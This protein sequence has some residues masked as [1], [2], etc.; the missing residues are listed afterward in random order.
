MIGK[1]AKVF[2]TSSHFPFLAPLPPVHL[3]TDH[4][5][6]END[7]SS[8]SSFFFGSARTSCTPFDFRPPTLGQDFFLSSPSPTPPRSP[9]YPRHR[10]HLRHPVT[11]VTLQPLST[12]SPRS[13]TSIQ[14]S[15]VTPPLHPVISP[16]HPVKF[17]LHPCYKLLQPVP[18]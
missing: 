14:S 10:L 8:L 1:S 16:L 17:L 4:H 5:W 6:F 3:R 18:P 2:N 9:A 7:N 11:S 12:P 15:P 13:S